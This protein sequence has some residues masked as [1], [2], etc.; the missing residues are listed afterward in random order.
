M[1]EYSVSIVALTVDPLRIRRTYRE[2]GGAW[3]AV[4]LTAEELS[5]YLK[6]PVSTI[7][8]WASRGELPGLRIG[9]SWQ[10]DMDEIL[11]LISEIKR[12]HEQSEPG[13]LEDRS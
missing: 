2:A 13:V 10:F 11:D 1:E 9:D 7:C 4:V 8:R 3:V 5:G 12:K 6:L